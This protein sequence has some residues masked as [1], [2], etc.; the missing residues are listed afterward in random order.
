[1]AKSF[2]PATDSWVAAEIPRTFSCDS[3]LQKRSFGVGY[4]R[5]RINI[6]GPINTKAYTFV[7]DV[8]LIILNVLARVQGIGLHG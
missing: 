3:R 6:L 7:D 2:V 1:M 4:S 8:P 5:E